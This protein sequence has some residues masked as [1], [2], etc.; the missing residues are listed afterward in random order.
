M[1][2][3]ASK[4]KHWCLAILFFEVLLLLLYPWTSSAVEL[5]DR[6]N[7]KILQV[8]AVALRMNGINPEED[9]PVTTKELLL[10]SLKGTTS[11]GAVEIGNQYVNTTFGGDLEVIIT[12]DVINAGNRCS[13]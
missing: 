1:N 12:G 4:K 2:A 6:A 13:N 7:M 11:C 8:R 3:T 5:D 9:L 10:E